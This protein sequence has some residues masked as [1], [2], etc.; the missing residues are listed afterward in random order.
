MEKNPLIYSRKKAFT[1]IELLVVI[2]VIGLLASVVLVSMGGTRQQA[3]VAQ[4][5]RFSQTLGN[6][7]G[8]YAKGWWS[9]ETIE[10]GGVVLDSSG[11]GNDC[12]VYGA[13]VVSGLDKLGNALSFGGDDWVQIEG[14]LEISGAMTIEFW[15]NTPNKSANQYFFD[16]RNPGTWWFIKNY[17]GGTCGTI[18]GNICFEGRV[19]AQDSDWNINEWTHIAV[20]DDTSQ[21]KMYINGKL[22][23][24]GSGQSSSIT[25]N[26]RIGTRYTNSG[27]FQGMIDEARV[28]ERALSVSEIRKH[29]AEGLQKYNNLVLK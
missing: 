17:T 9:F 16:N 24:T 18:P 3:R 13:S 8:A 1:L 6:N 10:T 23:D 27:Y 22:V 25:T 4:G 11:Y 20:T 7:F 12:T 19:M 2:S 21:A 28:Y 14:D 29:Y 15:F 5:L 26:L